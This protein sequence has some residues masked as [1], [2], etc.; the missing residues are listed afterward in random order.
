MDASHQ[1]LL[2]HSKAWGYGGSDSGGGMWALR[3]VWWCKRWR[4]GGAE[5]P[6]IAG[7]PGS[8]AAQVGVEAGGGSFTHKRFWEVHLRGAGED[9]QL[10]EAEPSHAQQQE[11]TTQHGNE[12]PGKACQGVTAG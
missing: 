2:P 12:D 11:D 5:P 4:E 3:R 9:V 10:D 1:Y 8:A 6:A 7:D